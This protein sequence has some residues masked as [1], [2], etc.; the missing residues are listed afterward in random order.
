M[1]QKFR[2]KLCSLQQTLPQG[3]SEFIRAVLELKQEYLLAIKSI[4]RGLKVFLLYYFLQKIFLFYIS[5]DRRA[6]RRR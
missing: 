5:L 4:P 3:G 2:Q 6:R 1:L